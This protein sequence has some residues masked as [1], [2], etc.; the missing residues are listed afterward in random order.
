MEPSKAK[1]SLPMTEE[2]KISLLSQIKNSKSSSDWSLNCKIQVLKRLAKNDAY[3]TTIKQ[4][5]IDQQTSEMKLDPLEHQVFDENNQICL[6]SSKWMCDFKDC[7][8]QNYRGNARRLAIK[9]D[10][11]DVHKLIFHKLHACLMHY[12][13]PD[14]SDKN[15]CHDFLKLKKKT[16]KWSLFVF[17]KKVPSSTLYVS[18]ERLVCSIFQ[19][20]L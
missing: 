5:W 13:V 12:C 1:K 11:S 16:T 8:F 4:A 10:K 17:Q 20:C 2:E 6:A 18:C 14:S 9:V 15:F 7:N 19:N 3:K